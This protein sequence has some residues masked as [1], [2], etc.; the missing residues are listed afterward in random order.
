MTTQHVP[1]E[2]RKRMHGRNNGPSVLKALQRSDSSSGEHTTHSF[3]PASVSPITMTCRP[4]T[5]QGRQDR[6][7]RSDGRAGAQVAECGATSARTRRARS[8]LFATCIGAGVR[9]V[10]AQKRAGVACAAP[11]FRYTTGFARGAVAGPP[12]GVMSSLPDSDG[13]DDRVRIGWQ[14]D[15]ARLRGQRRDATAG[16]ARLPPTRLLARILRSLARRFTFA[17]G[18]PAR[19]CVVT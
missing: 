9:S 15:A 5:G 4:A 14:P 18:P 19:R 16:Q 1:H 17:R 2:A 10:A 13:E 3:R 6:H 11:P 12:R 7:L 8:R